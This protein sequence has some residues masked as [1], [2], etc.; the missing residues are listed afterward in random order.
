LGFLTAVGWERRKETPLSEARV[1]RERDSSTKRGL[2][3]LQKK[4]RPHLP[5]GLRRG[6]R[7]QHGNEK[8]VPKT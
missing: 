7:E 4:P 1:K 3:P 8:K 6:Q 5:N 2:E